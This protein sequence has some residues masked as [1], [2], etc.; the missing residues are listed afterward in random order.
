MAGKNPVTHVGKLYDIAARTI[1]NALVDEL[2]EVTEAGC[3][4][5][6]QIG[7]PVNEPQIFDLDVRTV[8]D[9]RIA[10]MAPQV[11]KIACAKLEGMT[12]LWQRV[13]KGEV[14]L[15]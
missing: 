2:P 10:D 15:Y 6:S 11:R 5:V 3:A 12:T 4:L 1:A 13:L 8:A 9:Q 14:S 7:K